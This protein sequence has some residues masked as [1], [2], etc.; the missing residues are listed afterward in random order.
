M[1]PALLTSAA[2][3]NVDGGRNQISQDIL[4]ECMLNMPSPS[5]SQEP[6]YMSRTSSSLKADHMA[7]HWPGW[8]GLAAREGLAVGLQCRAVIFSLLP[9]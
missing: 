2:F 5:G 4:I 1:S 9:Q 3:A 7:S 6:R 8:L